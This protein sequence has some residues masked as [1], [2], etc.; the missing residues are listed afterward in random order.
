MHAKNGDNYM[1][2]Y[3]KQEIWANAHRM[4]ESL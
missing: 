2:L 1:H 3:F 4:R